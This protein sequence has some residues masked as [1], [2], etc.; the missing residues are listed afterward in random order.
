MH[1][2]DAPAPDQLQQLGRQ[3]EEWRNAH[4]PRSRLLEELWAA[5]V[6]LARQHGLFQTAH[7]LRLETGGRAG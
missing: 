6:E 1:S 5:A 4:R 3:L 7:T 2:K